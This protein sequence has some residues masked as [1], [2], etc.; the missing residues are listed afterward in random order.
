MQIRCDNPLVRSNKA[1]FITYIYLPSHSPI[2][3]NSFIH[4]FIRSVQYG[5]HLSRALEVHFHYVGIT[6]V[7]IIRVSASS[8]L[9]WCEGLLLFF[10]RLLDVVLFLAIS[11]LRLQ[12]KFICQER[13]YSILHNNTVVDIFWERLSIFFNVNLNFL[14]GRG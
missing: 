2:Q 5:A 14:L 4:S 13:D 8:W 12:F 6:R 7:V 11:C 3:I 1:G 10:G 9:F